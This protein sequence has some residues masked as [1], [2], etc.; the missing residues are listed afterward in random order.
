MGNSGAG[1]RDK[2]FFF[3]KKKNFLNKLFNVLK[4]MRWMTRSKI[5]NLKQTK[6][7]KTTIEEYFRGMCL[8]CSLCVLVFLLS[9]TAWK[10]S[11]F[12]VR[13]FRIFSISPYSV[14]MRE[15]AGQNSLRESIQVHL[16]TLK[17]FWIDLLLNFTMA[18]T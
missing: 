7:I 8:H 3:F 1:Q 15:N 13:I 6:L 18:M 10:V 11:V 14:R 5:R 9:F 4:E 16:S 2:F 17:R 12:G